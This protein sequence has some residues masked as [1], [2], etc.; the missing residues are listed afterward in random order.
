M[1]RGLRPGDLRRVGPYELAD[2]L[3]GAMGRA[4]LGWP[5]GRCPVAVTVIG[6]GLAGR[7][8]Q[9]RVLGSGGKPGEERLCPGEDWRPLR[10]YSAC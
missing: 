6:A 1:V 9:G 10:R 4:Y 2:V 7:M 5:A 3:G 8:P